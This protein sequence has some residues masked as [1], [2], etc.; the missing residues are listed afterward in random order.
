MFVKLDSKVSVEDLLQG[1]I[2][3]SG[4]DACIVLAEGLRGTEAAF[5]EEATQKAHEM[6]AT[7]STFL[8]STGWPDEGHLTTAKD[9]AIIA[10]RT[11]T[12]FQ[13]V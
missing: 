6:G 3:Q 1:V 10:E 11:I 4:N 5:A 8:N 13:R 9:L 12:I 2:V 7:N